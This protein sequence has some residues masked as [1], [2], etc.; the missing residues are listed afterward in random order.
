MNASDNLLEVK[1][2]SVSY[3]NIKAVREIS[4][5]VRKG[6]LVTLIG[7]NGSG[8]TSILRAIS[9]MSPC[10]GTITYS[11]R[12]L[13]NMPAHTIVSLGIAHVPEGRGIFGNLT[14]LENLRLAT[15]Q[16]KDKADTATRFEYVFSL[17]PRLK[18]RLK[19]PGGTLSGGEQQMLAVARALMTRTRMILLDEPSMGLSPKLAQEIFQMLGEISK[20]GM[21]ILLVEQNANMALHLASRGY[22]LEAG[23]I[24]LSGTGRELIDN[25]VVRTAYL[26]TG[27][28]ARSS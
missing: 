7:A 27:S 12:N 1:D 3:G 26:G 8:K 15:W 18:E 20:E 24:I 28:D 6:E 9:G 10:T 13:I 19:Q 22:V 11:G 25:P 21:T 14:V 23:S 5:T 4:F 16:S 17:F 2:L